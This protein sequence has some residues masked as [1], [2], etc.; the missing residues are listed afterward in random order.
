MF[1]VL[2]VKMSKSRE[3]PKHHVVLSCVFVS[4][5]LWGFSIL[6]PKHLYHPSRTTQRTVLTRKEQVLAMSSTPL[7]PIQYCSFIELCN[8]P[9]SGITP[10]L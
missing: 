10:L 1:Y 8:I 5:T 7:P 2:E 9:A 3:A 6:R 4:P